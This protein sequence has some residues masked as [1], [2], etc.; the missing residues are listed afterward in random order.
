MALT[1]FLNI[2][3]K[4]RPYGPLRL[5][6]SWDIK[7]WSLRSWV[8]VFS[9][10][11]NK[12]YI[13]TERYEIESLKDVVQ[14]KYCFHC[15]HYFLNYKGSLLFWGLKVTNCEKVG[16]SSWYSKIMDQWRKVWM[17]HKEGGL[18]EDS[19]LAGTS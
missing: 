8:Q 15:K 5:K 19:R 13:S 6:S 4:R 11:L 16:A 17:S 10:K 2:C 18:A 14:P 3:V 1:I 12:S 7:E 9:I